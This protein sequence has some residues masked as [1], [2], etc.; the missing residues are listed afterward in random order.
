MIMMLVINNQIMIIMIRNNRMIKNKNQLII[1]KI[2]IK[3]RMKIK[4]SK[5]ETII[6]SIY[7]QM[8]KYNKTLH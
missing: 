8:K 2:K 5:K 3:I 1:R 6:N 7:G 4:S